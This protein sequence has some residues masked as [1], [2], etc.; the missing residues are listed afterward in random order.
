G[1]THRNERKHEV[2]RKSGAERKTSAEREMIR[3][4]VLPAPSSAVAFS[5]DELQT[6]VKPAKLRQGRLLTQI[7]HE[8]RLFHAPTMTSVQGWCDGSKIEAV[9]RLKTLLY[10]RLDAQKASP[11]GKPPMVRRYR[12]GPSAM[13]RDQRTGRGTARLDSV[14]EGH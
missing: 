7:N 8:V 11:V 6:E 9:E 2:E 5:P 14:L 10:A 3:V 13:V 12:L 4:V 1:K